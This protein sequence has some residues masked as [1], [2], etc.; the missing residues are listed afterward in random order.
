[1]ERTI[2]DYIR[3]CSSYGVRDE[4]CRS[5]VDAHPRLT[6]AAVYVPLPRRGRGT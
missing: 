3:A 1:M 2:I 4:R 5:A 6:L